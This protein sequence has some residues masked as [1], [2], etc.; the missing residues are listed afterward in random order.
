[1]LDPRAVANAVLTRAE[2][3]DRPITNLDMQKI[4]YFLHGAYL[5][6]HGRPLVAGEFE[7]WQYGPVHRV[8]YDAFKQY[9]DGPITEPAQ[10]F[11]PVRRTHR[12]ISGLDDS[13]AIMLIR[14]VLDRFLDI[15]TW[16]LVAITHAEGTPWQRTYAE[17]QR[18]VNVGMRISNELIAE[19][20]EVA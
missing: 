2:E 3:R 14:E 9:G 19:G 5:R 1:M 13:D 12:P 7:A 6:R 11:D 20:F 10:A 18:R 15:P 8:L 16:T 4:V 17:G